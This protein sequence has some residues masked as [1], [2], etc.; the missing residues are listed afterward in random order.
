MLNYLIIFLIILFCTY[1]LLPKNILD[2][3]L[4]TIKKLG[5]FYEKLDSK[6]QLENIDFSKIPK[7]K[8]KT[9]KIKKISNWFFRAIF[10]SLAFIVIVFWDIFWHLLFK[11]LFE[12]LRALK[13]YEKFK[14][15]INQKANKY[16]VLF[17]FISLFLIMEYFGIYSGILAVQGEV[18]LAILFYIAKFLMVFPVKILYQE[19]HDKLVKIT[20]FNRRKELF[21]SAL[22]WFESTSSFKKA[23]ELFH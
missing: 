17:I 8:I 2:F 1:E 12:F 4:K 16:F 18:L 22:L 13:I 19:G 5:S 20:W 9:T 3:A 11:R 21:V 14:I 15:Y 23:K 10:L 6:I 7:Q